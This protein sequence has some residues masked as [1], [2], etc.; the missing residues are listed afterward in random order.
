[1][2]DLG[3]IKKDHGVPLFY[4][5]AVAS[6][7]GAPVSA[8]GWNID[9]CLGATQ[10][11]L[12]AIPD[13]AYVAVSDAA[14]EIIDKVDYVGYDAL[15]PFKNARIEKYF[16]YTPN[17][18]AMAALNAAAELI[19]NEGLEKCFARHDE[20]AEYC[21]RQLID[22]G[23]SLFPAPDA[24]PSP[25]VT[26]INVPTGITW[27]ELDARFRQEGLAAAGNYGP[28]AGK[29][30]RIG[31]MGTQ[32]DMELVEGALDVIKRVVRSL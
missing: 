15:K 13:L 1:L 32:A 11:C 29:V 17:W 27:P 10:K 18:H 31:H 21:R 5:D 12:S 22:M 7:G 14:W 24:V 6:M 16:P 4:V 9:L 3:R 28:L 25:T 30:F 20:V 19:L 23:Q 26:A 8:D 2:A